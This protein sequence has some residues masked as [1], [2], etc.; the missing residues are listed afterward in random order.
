MKALQTAV[1]AAATVLFASSALAYKLDEDGSG[2]PLHWAQ[3]AMPVR[4]RLVSGNVPLGA[5]GEAAVKRA[6]DSWDSQTPNLS[7]SYDGYSPTAA[8]EF[9]GKNVVSWIDR[10]WP[11][12]SNL[13]AV[14]LRYSDSSDGRLLDADIVFNGADYRWSVGGFD[15][16]IENT[17]A[18]EVGHFGGLGHSTVQEAT[19]HP[20][21]YAGET[22][23]R[24]LAADD[25][26]GLDAV[27]G[28]VA[29]A[30][31]SGNQD[32][33]RPPATVGTS[34]RGISGGGSGGGCSITARGRRS[35]ASS[36]LLSTSLLLG[37]LAA[38]RAAARRRRS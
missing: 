38:R 23:K 35:S 22:D 37:C 1:V 19:M 13:L 31:T 4:W 8:H 26:N 20:G 9:D 18:H 2:H 27:Y 36:E 34:A 5:L 29:G 12:D 10:N 30:T 28:G 3:D 17:A 6:F 33:S 24:S 16:D 32:A 21:A 15:F 11:Y 25:L 7:Y 14:T